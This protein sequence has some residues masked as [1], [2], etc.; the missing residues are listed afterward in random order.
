MNF[1]KVL[2]LLI[3]TIFLFN[4]VSA[5]MTCDAVWTDGTKSATITNGD[6]I[7]FEVICGT[8]YPSMNLKVELYDS[9]D[10]LIY[11]FLNQNRNSNDYTATYTINKSTYGSVGNFEINVN[12]IDS[13]GNIDY[14]ELTLKVNSIVIPADTTVP[15]ITLNGNNPLTITQGNS[16][17]ELGATAIDNIDGNIT[18]KIIISGNVNTNVIGTY[19]VFYYVSDNTGN[20]ATSTRVVNVIAAPTDTT[21]PTITI[22]SPTNNSVY[23]FT[24]HFLNF[25][26]TDNNLASCSYSTNNGVTKNSVSCSS[27]EL[28]TISLTASE[29]ANTWII[30]A[31][32]NSGN[33]ANTSISFIVNTT[34]TDTT[35]PVITIISPTENETIK[36]KSL[37]IELTTD[38]NATV[39]FK[40]DE[41]NSKT[42]DNDE[43]HI[44]TYSLNKLHNGEHTLTITATDTAGNVATKNVTF[45]INKKSSKSSGTEI[46]NTDS[47]SLSNGEENLIGSGMIKE[48]KIL[49]EKKIEE[50]SCFQKIINSIIKFFKKLFGGK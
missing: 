2:P 14:S 31:S 10:N 29:G 22:Q 15:V 6:S 18:S 50:V 48:V 12:G 25:I 46:V 36:S 39:K 37:D 26:A 34:I 27:G 32:D 11:T 1:S 17:T 3:L 21:A 30:Y 44:F 33:E 24:N 43:D 7:N 28:T 13:D 47:T 38:E 23:N 49:D 40:L 41:G 9:S 20:M 8:M 19:S 4:G 16:Y 42:M 5:T 45:E 35:A